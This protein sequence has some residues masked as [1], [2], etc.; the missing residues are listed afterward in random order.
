MKTYL[1]ALS[2]IKNQKWSVVAI[3]IACFVLSILILIEPFFFKEIIDRLASYSGESN[4]LKGILSIFLIWAGIVLTNIL[5]QIGVSY[6]S[7]FLANKIYCDLWKKTF[8]HI[9]SLSIEFFQSNKL[10]TIVRNFERGLDNLYKLQ[11]NFF[12]HILTN[13]FIILILVPTLFYLNFKMALLILLTVPFLAFFVFFGIKKAM[14][15]QKV[16]DEKWSELSGIAYDSI[17]NI[18]LIQSFTLRNNLFK[19]IKKLMDLAYTKHVNTIKWWGFIIGTSRSIGLVLNILVFLI[20]SYLFTQSEISLGSIIMFVGFSSILINIFYSIFWNV[21]DYSWQR[22]KINLFLEIWDKK[23]KITNVENAFELGR[24]KGEIEFKKVSFSYK[25]EVEAL[26][27]I[28]FKIKAG[29]VVAFVGH[30]GSGKTTTA[31]LISRFYDIQKGEI[32]ID[33]YNLK[34]V[35]LDSLRKNIA[36]VFQ[37]N[38]FLNTSFLE[39]LRINNDKI[40]KKEIEKACKQA[41][42]WNLI[43]KNKK[44]LNEVIGDRGVRLSGGEKQRLSIARAILKDAPILILDEATSAL[45]AKTESKIQLAISNVIKNRTTIIIAHRLSTIKKADRIFVF[46]NGRIVEEGNFESLMKTKAKFYDLASHQITI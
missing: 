5:I 37:D 41:Y 40:D 16:S 23:P 44:G 12:R 4:F 3:V 10:G 25:D 32:L 42:I 17:N 8:N 24:V 30:T 43:S 34:E 36:I 6:Y 33:G 28:S 22:E 7:S 9:L 20:G 11:M 26:K 38:T 39:N 29:E 13:T 19:K 27:N 14:Q 15:S 18:S 35:E 46:E 45:D 1:R 21:L 2:F 31:N